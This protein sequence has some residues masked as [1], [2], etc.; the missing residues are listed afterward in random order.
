MS[1]IVLD[2]HQ[3]EAVQFVADRKKAGL[4][5]DVGTG[6]T[7]TALELYRV[8][9]PESLLIVT[10]NKLVKAKQWES[11][12]TTYLGYMPD[13]IT[14]VNYEKLGRQDKWKDMHF[15]MIVY[16][17]AH[18][19]K[20][21]SSNVSKCAKILSKKAR[22]VI[23]MTATPSGNDY[24]DIFHIYQNCDIPIWQG[25]HTHQF[26]LTYYNCQRRDYSGAGFTTLIP[27]SLKEDQ[28]DNLM[29]LIHDHA[30]VVTQE[31]VLT[32]PPRQEHP[33][34]IDGMRCKEYRDITEGCFT[35]GRFPTTLMKLEQIAKEHQAAQ[36]FVYDEYKQPI[37]FN[38]TKV[39]EL[40][41]LIQNRLFRFNKIVMVYYFNHD[42]TN[43]IGV[44]DELG[45]S[46]TDDPQ[47]F[48]DSARVMFLQYSQAEGLNL[49]FANCMV[50][51]SY[52]YSYIQYDQMLGRIYRRGQTRKCHVYYMIGK[53]TVEE[54]IF[55]AIKHK[56][57]K[58]QF[59]KDWEGTLHTN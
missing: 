36:G 22:Y 2:D 11:E 10:I 4:F 7:F 55:D 26:M 29:K 34:V 28:V 5:M 20:S 12:I 6:K 53:G 49:Q 47:E 18:K 3:N 58:N 25:W 38:D 57:S 24:I 13:N 50:F 35:L 42:R 30:F 56:K 8:F 40:K 9:Q 43:I 1:Q 51:Y 41:Y 46:Y 45:I 44:L 17:E 31:Q 16:D 33:I 21:P 19:I 52:G 32:L 23:P 54:I 37:Q 48:K 27:V 39:R 15:D 14:V 59:L